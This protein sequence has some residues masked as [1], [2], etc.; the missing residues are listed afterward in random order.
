MAFDL[1]GLGFACIILMAYVLQTITG[2]GSTVVALSLG[3]IWYS[4]DELLPFLIFTNI[5][6]TSFLAYKNRR[7]IHKH[8]AL[9]IVLPGMLIGT[10]LGYLIKSYLDD[11]LLKKI[12][13]LLIVWVSS[14][15]LWRLYKDQIPIMHSTIKSRLL[16]LLAGLS[17][18]IFAS[19]G[20]LLVYAI[21]GFNVNKAQFRATVV[22]CLFVLNCILTIAF[23]LDGRLQPVLPFVVAAIPLILIAVKAGN[24]I[25]NFV[26]EELFKKGI[27]ILL[28]LSGI[29]LMVGCHLT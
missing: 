13:G 4:I 28:L 20:P 3:A 11:E 8:L 5:L 25:H 29:N 27:F 22:V 7:Y 21:A 18:G 6:F 14:L 2:F 26:N 15:E 10:V 17:H 1:L 9:N 12:L 16:T 19:G 23:L 24:Y